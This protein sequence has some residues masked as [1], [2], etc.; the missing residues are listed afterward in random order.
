M[1]I[2]SLS[3]IAL[4]LLSLTTAGAQTKVMKVNAIKANNYGVE[5]VLPK[6]QLVVEVHYTETRCEAGPYARY[7]SRYLGL[8]ESAVVFEDETFF[9]LNKVDLSEKGIPNKEQTYL[10]EFKAK[11]VAPFV[12]LTPDGMIRTINAECQDEEESHET[13]SVLAE[14][15]SF[16]SP[17]SI[18]TEEYLRAGSVSKMAEVAAKNIYS[19]RE[20][21]QDILTGEIENMPKDGEAMKIVLASLEEQERLWTELFTGKKVRKT[22]THRIIIDPVMELEREVLF[23]FSKY[24]GIVG[25]DDLSGSPVY[26]NLKDLKTVDIPEPD[27]KRKAKEPQSIVYNLP[28]KALI[29]VFYGTTSLYRGEHDVTQLGTTQIL[30][31]KMF[32]EKNQPVKVYFYP[33]TGA[34]KQIIQ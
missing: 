22:L 15:K 20:S 5:Y 9:Y 8:D 28:G 3:L 14:N 11:S 4:F 23:R 30:G 6:T 34:I 31:T 18:F 19:I 1:K 12:C 33:Q 21:R 7:A 16:I 24:Y 29:E 26:L 27:P 17:Q 25:R 13:P 32:E 2:R 10:V